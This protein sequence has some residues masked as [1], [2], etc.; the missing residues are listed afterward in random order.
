VRRERRRAGCRSPG[1]DAT[2]SRRWP[3]R[4]GS[5]SGTRPSDAR[6]CSAISGCLR[7]WPR[8]PVR[9]GFRR[10]PPSRRVL[11]RGDV[12]DAGTMPG[13][14]DTTRD[15]HG[16][17]SPSR[18]DLALSRSADAEDRRSCGGHP[19]GV[20]T[21][22]GRVVPLPLAANR[23]AVAPN[24]VART[25]GRPFVC[26]NL[27]TPRAPQGALRRRRANL[28][29]HERIHGQLFAKRTP[30]RFVRAGDATAAAHRRRPRSVVGQPTGLPRARFL[31]RT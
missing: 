7:P 24:R 19:V 5:R 4:T 18:G 11:A 30:R 23:F 14:R 13:P 2:R 1:C 20:L 27:D 3:P 28:H 8:P 16:A 12:P 25:H 6:R 22:R 15:A 10:L 26:T 9:T 21:S 29:P 31:D 17:L